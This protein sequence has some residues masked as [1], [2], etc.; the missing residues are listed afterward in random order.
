MQPLRGKLTVPCTAGDIGIIWGQAGTLDSLKEELKRSTHAV[1]LPPQRLNENAE[2]VLKD[3]EALGLI[4][5]LS[6]Q[7]VQ[8]PDVYR[9]AFGLGRR[10]G[11][12]PLK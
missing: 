10:G 3:L 7:R 6:D 11:V 2:G 12:K 9:I 1:K 5:R 4:N 8:M